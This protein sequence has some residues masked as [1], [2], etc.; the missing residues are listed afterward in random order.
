MKKITLYTITMVFALTLSVAYAHEDGK[1][2]I[3]GVT[4]F[5]GGTVDTI[6]DL[7]GVGPGAMDHSYMEGANAGGIR[8]EEPAAESYNGVTIFNGKGASTH[9]DLDYLFTI[10]VFA[11]N[12]KGA[13]VK[14]SNAGGI[15]PEEPGPVLFNGITDFTGKTYDS[16]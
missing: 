3:N 5:T 13:A 11:P 6:Y 8:S 4:D 1:T 15:R 14:S 10:G 7:N 16:M 2:M 9:A 12:M